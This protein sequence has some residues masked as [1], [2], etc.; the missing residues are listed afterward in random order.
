M[1]VVRQPV[2][3]PSRSTETN[4]VWEPG[5]TRRYGCPFGR[6][7]ITATVSTSSPRIISIDSKVVR[8]SFPSRIFH[9]RDK[10]DRERAY[11]LDKNTLCRLRK[12]LCRCRGNHVRIS[13]SPTLEV[14]IPDA[15]TCFTSS[16]VISACFKTS[17]RQPLIAAFKRLLLPS[18]AVMRTPISDFADATA[19]YF[20]LNRYTRVFVVPVSIV[21]V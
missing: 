17:S 7:S 18:I 4:F 20:S 21:I 12:V 16:Y 2:I 8:S 10:E 19:S 9:S 15:A 1:I 11:I 13:V 5:R 14:I 6:L 3:F